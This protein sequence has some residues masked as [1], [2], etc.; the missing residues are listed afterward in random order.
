M[1]SYSAT[2][3][4]LGASSNPLLESWTAQPFSLPP[5]DKIET[6]HYQ[7]ALQVG[8]EEQ[9]EDLQK[10]VGNPDPPTFDNVFVAYDRAGATLSKVRGVFSNMC[11]SKNT[12]DLQEVQT[13]MTPILSRHRSSTCTLPGL[14][15]KMEQVRN[16]VAQDDDNTLTT[17][18]KRLV[19]RIYLD[20]TRAGAHFDTD[21][22]QE[23]ADLQAKLACLSTQFMQNGE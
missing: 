22:Q 15:Q 5:F 11:S 7:P 13:T 20:F 2:T 1:T 12:P 8:M 9:L 17:E 18:D 16:N 19:E 3:C 14:F 10:I 4:S 6:H 23:Y 21:K